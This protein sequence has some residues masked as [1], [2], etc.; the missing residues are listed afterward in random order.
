LGLAANS[1]C[2]AAKAHRATL[3]YQLSTIDSLELFNHFF[4]LRAEHIHLTSRVASLAGSDSIGAN[5]LATERGGSRQCHF[6]P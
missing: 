6:F 2:G 5:E 3:N 1:Q 4:K